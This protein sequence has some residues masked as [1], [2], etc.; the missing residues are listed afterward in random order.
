MSPGI[1]PGPGPGPGPG[2]GSTVGDPLP[3]VILAAR[4]Q[5]MVSSVL[6]MDPDGKNP[7]AL[8]LKSSWPTNPS[9][10]RTGQ[11][12]AYVDNG[13]YSSVR[14]AKI[15]GTVDRVLVEGAHD[16][17]EPAFSPDGTKIAFVSNRT[18][19]PQIFTA[20]VS[21]GSV[22]QLTNLPNGA[23]QPRFSPDGTQIV[24][25]TGLDTDGIYIMNADGT[26][27]RAVVDTAV[28][29]SSPS[30]SPNGE[31]VVYVANLAR[32]GSHVG[33]IMIVPASGGEPVR[34]TFS[35]QF[36]EDPTSAPDGTKILFTRK[37]GANGAREI[38]SMPAGG[39]SAAQLT[40]DG[41][42][43]SS[44]RLPGL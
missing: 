39:G 35:M 13:L 18:G 38:M 37:I 9:L 3:P 22:R 42:I 16:N 29:E 44:L 11:W 7:R 21:D 26:D 17:F 12:V 2:N 23:V 10:D 8:P 4:E 33:Q 27:I 6:L 32:D 14:L 40:A 31:W 25:V 15:D 5:G 34:R 19:M 28:D 1:G 24:F 30:F 20:S 36:D 41:A 43:Y